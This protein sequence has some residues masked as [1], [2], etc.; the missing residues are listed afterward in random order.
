MQV[1]DNL[2]Q[3]K[4]QQNT[5]L[6]IGSFDGVHRGHQ[7]LVGRIL[8]QAREKD[9][10][11]GLIT[12]YPHPAA[13]LSPHKAPTFLTTPGE[14]I[15]LLEK[16]GLDLVAILPFDHQMAHTSARDF[17]LDVKKHLCLQELWIG[18]DFALGQKREGNLPVLRALGQQLG[19]SVRPIEPFLWEGKIISSTRIR[20]H[21][22]AGQVRQ[23]ASL[24][25]RYPSLSGEVV[26]GAGRGRQLNIPTANLAV[27]PDRAMPANGIYAV[28]AVLGQERYPG[29]TNIGVRP[30]FADGARTIETH[31][32]DFSE[33]IYG[34]DL[35]IEFV[36]RLRD[37][38]QF[39]SAEELIAQIRQ[40][41]EQAKHI[42]IGAP[43]SQ[44]IEGEDSCTS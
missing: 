2:E 17:M 18:P 9:M 7:H 26:S 42:L 19:F 41:I 1:I 44:Q 33:N 38:Q 37:E 10:L 21:L 29:V 13:I 27:R 8:Q 24:L 34:I 30:S 32:L 11:A 3:I 23:A 6:T 4:L 39:N 40:D 20:R 16:L 28:Y 31:I 35:V 36:E 12:F 15:A 22:A 5:V 43:R 25:G 14:K